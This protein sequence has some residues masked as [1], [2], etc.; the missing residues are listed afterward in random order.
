MSTAI[1]I[2]YRI[3][4][5]SERLFAFKAVTFEYLCSSSP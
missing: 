5:T 2:K 4:A 3:L 1:S